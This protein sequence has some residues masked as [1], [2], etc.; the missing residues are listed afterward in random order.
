[1]HPL[2]Q[3]ITMIPDIIFLYCQLLDAVAA[4]QPTEYVRFGSASQVTVPALFTLVN[5]YWM[6]IFAGRL[7]V[8]DQRWLLAVYC[9]AFRL[10]A[11]LTSQTPRLA[12]FPAL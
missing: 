11:L 5:L 4:A 12:T 3:P 6:T 10:T 8:P 1:M 7:T 9:V 2:L